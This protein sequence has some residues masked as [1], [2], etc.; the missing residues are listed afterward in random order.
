MEKQTA[1]EW[2]IHQL[3]HYC[4]NLSDEFIQ[5]AKAMEKEQMIHF[6]ETMPQKS[7]ITQEGEPYVQYD[8]EQH[9]NNTYENNK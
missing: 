8:A 5:K 7:G 4:I 1:V 9:Y 2:L 6:A 3:K